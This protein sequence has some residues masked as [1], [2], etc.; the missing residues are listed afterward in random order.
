M[1]GTIR[2]RSKE[3]F[4]ATY[5]Q[6]FETIFNYVWRRVG[7][8]SDAEDL[9][10]T[11]YLKAWRAWPKFR[12]HK[13]T[14]LPWLYRIAGNEM[15]SYFRKHQN[16]KFEELT[17]HEDPVAT[18]DLERRTEWRQFRPVLGQAM[19]SLKTLDQDLLALR[20]F[21]GLSFREI[22]QITGK[23]EGS[24]IMR[25]QRALARLQETLTKKGYDHER[26]E[27]CFD[28]SGERIHTQSPIQGS[29]ACA[30]PR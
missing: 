7:T 30:P 9:T 22:A 1:N 6:T 5:E 23:R 27:G 3:R 20:F 14:A 28:E 12:E 19:A 17:D 8:R 2:D 4:L 29:A 26:F 16:L 11:V 15:S 10:A 21:E 13:G 18:T 24:V 25:V